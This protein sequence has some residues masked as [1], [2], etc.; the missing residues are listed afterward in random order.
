MISDETNQSSYVTWLLVALIC[1]SFPLSIYPFHPTRPQSISSR[2]ISMELLKRSQSSLLSE[3][4]WTIHCTLPRSALRG[5]CWT[6][7]LKPICEEKHTHRQTHNYCCRCTEFNSQLKLF[8]FFFLP[9][10]C[11]VWR[12]V[13]RPCLC[14]QRRMTSP[15]IIW[16]TT[17]TLLFLPAGTLKRGI[18][19][20]FILFIYSETETAGC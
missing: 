3:T 7:S 8:F 10:V 16:G 20:V 6:C 15:G 17:E 2:R 9:P 19:I 18:L 13:W 14:L 11:W 5:C 1:L 12:R 4:G